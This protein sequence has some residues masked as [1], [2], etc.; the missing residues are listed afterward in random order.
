MKSKSIRWLGITLLVSIPVLV[1]TAA[2]SAINGTSLI[3]F[4]AH[5]DTTS[6]NLCQDSGANCYLSAARETI[7]L[8]GNSNT[9][10][11]NEDG[12]YFFAVLEPGG[13]PNPNDQGGIQDQNLSDDFDCY[14]NR[15]FQVKNGKI[16]SY[17]GNI[18]CTS[19]GYAN[20]TIFNHWM[21]S[22]RNEAGQ[23]NLKPNNQPPLIRLFPYSESNT[24]GEVYLLTVCS[25]E[26]GYP[27]D[28]RRCKYD[29]FRVNQ[30]GQG[31][32]SFFLDGYKVED[33][34]TD[35]Y[36]D[37]DPG[38]G[39][40]AI[41]VS[42]TGPDGLPIE[43]KVYTDEFGY[44]SYVSEVYTPD[45]KEKPQDVVLT[46]CQYPQAGWNQSFPDGDECYLFN[47]TPTGFD[48]FLGVNFADWR[49]VRVTTCTVQDMDGRP[50]GETV[51][52]EGWMVSLA[53]EGVTIGAHPTGNDGCYIWEG[54]SSGSN[55]SVHAANRTGWQTFGTTDRAF[56]STEAYSGANLVY[57]FVNAPLQGCQPDIWLAGNGVEAGGGF[58]F[59]DSLPDPDWR[60]VNAQ[61]FAHRTNFCEF[62]GGCIGEKSML[63]YIS[64]ASINADGKAFDKAA[65]SLIAAY[66]NASWGMN[67][68][69]STTQ[70]RVKWI[71]ALETSEQ[72]LD[73][74]SEL[75]AANRA[76]SRS[77]GIPDC[78]ILVNLK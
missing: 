6:N 72:L 53:E 40:W 65:R 78:P 68:A 22:G 63:D 36:D 26:E 33:L 10:I 50:G 60:G 38:L 58:G 13:Q 15:T 9:N 17:T 27:V 20:Y 73:L 52:V 64:D 62:F 16:F 49:P 43:A 39:G 48:R 55:Y 21:D 75:D 35:G 12:V 47:F 25:L 77:E 18:D 57:T 37:V 74:F 23:G 8:N 34:Y 7:W 42:G 1:I 28:P 5:V 2:G 61:P 76:F 24:P 69:Y 45:E 4:N 32:Y 19:S 54:L 46:I 71:A 51:P 56:L 59:W 66:L 30:G 29:A 67:Y 14:L 44:W 11:F 70:L 31:S 41:S 3:S